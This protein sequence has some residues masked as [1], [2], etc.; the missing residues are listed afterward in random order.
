[1]TVRNL[2]LLATTLSCALA[3]AQYT[4][5]DLG[6]LPMGSSAYGYKI[7]DNGMVAGFSMTPQG[8]R[9]F[10]WTREGGMVDV[11]VLRNDPSSFSIALNNS[12]RVVGYSGSGAVRTGFAWTVTGGITDLGTYGSDSMSLALD[13]NDGGQIVGV[14]GHDAGTKRAFLYHSMT[15]MIDLGPVPGRTTS[16]ARGINGAGNVVGHSSGST[17]LA[18]VWRPGVGMTALQVLAAGATSEAYE[19]SEAGKIVGLAADS[20]GTN[21]AVVWAGPSSSPVRLDLGL[22]GHEGTAAFDVNELGQA[23]GYGLFGGQERALYFDPVLGARRLDTMLGSAAA[24]WTLNRAQ[25]INEN[26]EIVGYGVFN[27]QTRA[28]VAS[29]VPEP[30]TLLVILAGTGL[31]RL[32]SRKNTGD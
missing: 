8:A 31:L 23:V 6:T 21:H 18:F 2:A 29:P 28:F 25:G 11:G 16:F 32:R 15:G 3:S 4:V 5:T 10:A 7:N 20:A 27:G 9:G 22:S 12:G 19:I 24:G 30:G 13:T 17:A 1:M 26:G 14:S